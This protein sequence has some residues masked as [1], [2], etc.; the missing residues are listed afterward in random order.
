V[1]VLGCTG[2]MGVAKEMEKLLKRDGYDVPVVNPVAASLKL[3]E[4]LVSMK[5]KQSRLTYMPPPKKARSYS[6]H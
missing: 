1:L 3:A 2:M 4:S 6:P 5:L